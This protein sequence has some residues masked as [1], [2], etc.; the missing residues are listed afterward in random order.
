MTA[1][2]VLVI[3]ISS[4]ALGYTYGYLRGRDDENR[5]GS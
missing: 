5:F 3:L 1:L 4:F 2:C